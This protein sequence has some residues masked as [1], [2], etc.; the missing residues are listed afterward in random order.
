VPAASDIGLSIEFPSGTDD[1]VFF[2]YLGNAA[3]DPVIPPIKVSKLVLSP[4]HRGVG[5][6]EE[7][8]PP[9]SEVEVQ[10]LDGRDSQV[11][12]PLELRKER[13]HNC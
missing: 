10:Q 9:L 13:C 11:L 3:L 7:Q 2:P 5:D 4:H 12:L 6:G 8:R 1:D